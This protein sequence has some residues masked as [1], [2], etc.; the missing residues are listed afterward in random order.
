MFST[1]RSSSF[2]DRARPTAERAAPQQQHGMSQP[3][4]E[5]APRPPAAAVLRVGI[6]AGKADEDVVVAPGIPSSHWVDEARPEEVHT[7]VAIWWRL[8]TQF[9]GVRAELLTPGDGD[10]TAE[11]LRANDV[12]LLLGWDAVSAHI[13]EFGAVDP[14]ADPPP[15]SPTDSDGGG[16]DQRPGTCCPP[17][18]PPRSPPC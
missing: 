18:C 8:R 9:S 1:K 11:R 13:E 16:D 6:V 15:P 4:A 17:R 7:D 3:P 12:N 2:L 14:A 5:P 10:I